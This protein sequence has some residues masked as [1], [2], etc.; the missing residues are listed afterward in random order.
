LEAVIYRSI[1]KFNA[2]QANHKNLEVIPLPGFGTYMAGIAGFDGAEFP[3]IYRTISQPAQHYRYVG[4]IRKT[5]HHYFPVITKWKST[6]HKKWPTIRCCGRPFF[7]K[8]GFN[9]KY[10]NQNLTWK[11]MVLPCCWGQGFLL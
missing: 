2:H 6:N 11:R 9:S 1:H 4:V 7:T 10:Q 5:G 8:A 3:V